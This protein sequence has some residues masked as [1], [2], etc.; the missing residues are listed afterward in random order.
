MAE[1]ELLTVERDADFVG[2]KPLSVYV[3]KARTEG[4]IVTS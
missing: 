4:R 1:N 2:E 3:E